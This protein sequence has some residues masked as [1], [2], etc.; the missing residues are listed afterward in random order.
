MLLQLNFM[1]GDSELRKSLPRAV[2]K[3]QGIFITNGSPP[4]GLYS[5][6][7]SYDKAVAV[8]K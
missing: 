4:P 7:L 6:I 1:L 5:F 2:N 3:T 8:T